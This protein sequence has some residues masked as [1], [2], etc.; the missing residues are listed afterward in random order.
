LDKFGHSNGYMRKLVLFFGFQLLFILKLYANTDSTGIK[1]INGKIFV[2]HKVEKGQGLYGIARRYGSTVEKIQQA[3]PD[4]KNGIKP[5]QIVLVPYSK[6]VKAKETVEEKP[7][8]K[9]PAKKTTKPKPEPVKDEEDEK[10]VAPGDEK[11][12]YH[13]VKNKESLLDIA[14]NNKV[15]MQQIRVWNKLKKDKLKPGQKLIVGYGAKPEAPEKPEK[16]PKKPKEVKTVPPK[17]KTKAE[18]TPNPEKTTKIK[19]APEKTTKDKRGKTTN[20]VKSTNTVKKEVNESG[21][22]SWVDDG[23]IKN[24]VNLAMHKTAPVGTIIRLKNPM[25]SKIIYVKVVAELPKTEENENI[26]IKIGKNT[27]D[28]LDIRDKVFRVDMTYSMDVEK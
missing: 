16:T 21:M 9:T 25:N 11:P 18:K 13:T 7:A 20:T 6:H 2:M 4:A 3:N 23:S 22:G 15:T 8:T 5:G 17:G 12:L 19:P 26:V 27:A 24:E 10:P 28:G 14:L 1:T